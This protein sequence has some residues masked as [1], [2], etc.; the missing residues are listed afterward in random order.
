MANPSSRFT[1]A[2]GYRPFKLPVEII[3]T[4][5]CRQSLWYPP[6]PN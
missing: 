4:L 6:Q 3:E 2:S 1:A 5:P